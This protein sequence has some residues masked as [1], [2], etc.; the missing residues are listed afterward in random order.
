[1][2]SDGEHL[3]D[4]AAKSTDKQGDGRFF[5]VFALLYLLLA[6]ILCFVSI[7]PFSPLVMP[8]PGADLIMERGGYLLL[9]LVLLGAGA[10]LF[11]RAWKKRDIP[12][13]IVTLLGLLFSG[14]VVLVTF[15][16]H[17]VQLRGVL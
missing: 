4:Y 7:L 15:L 3:F 9:D 8:A 10:T 1:V 13:L 5:V 12:S 11:Y 14:Y 17:V 6:G 2:D 16:A